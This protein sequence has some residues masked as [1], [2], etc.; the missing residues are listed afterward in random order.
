MKILQKKINIP[1]INMP[2]EVFSYTKKNCKKDSKIG[3]LA[4]EG[5]LKTGVYNKFFDKNFTLIKD[6]NK[7]ELPKPIFHKW[8]KLRKQRKL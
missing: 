2:K 7:Y 5:T 8:E 4:T 6:P 3:L 1:I